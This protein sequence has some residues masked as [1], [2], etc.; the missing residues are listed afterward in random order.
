MTDTKTPLLGLDYLMPEQ[1]QK[2]VT[3]NDALRRLDGMVQLAV[4][5][6]TT[7]APPPNPQNGDR[8]LIAANAT[9]AWQRHDGELAFYQD[10]GW[11]FVTPQ[12][13][14]TLWDSGD[15]TLLV[16]SSQQWEA[17]EVGATPT[18]PSLIQTDEAVF[19][20]GQNTGALPIPSHITLLGVTARVLQ[21][22]EGPP[23]W[24]LG[25]D[26]GANRFGSGLNTARGS[27]A[28]GP[29]DPPRVYWSSEH[30]TITANGSAF[31]AGRVTAAVH[32]IRL[33]LPSLS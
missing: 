26:Q 32:Y 28:V 6:R 20:L 30:V 16:F 27:T 2:H 7:A 21:T 18:Q 11:G 9:G 29:A 33:P 3:M 10:T 14:W 25:T 5:N 31:T 17:I 1:A 4:I 8:Y 19:D 24:N 23:N 22:I 13:G 15:E 12:S